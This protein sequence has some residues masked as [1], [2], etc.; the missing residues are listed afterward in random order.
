MATRDE[1]ETAIDDDPD[2]ADNYLVLADLLQELVDPRGEL[3]TL[4]RRSGAEVDA[5]RHAL[6]R[7]LAPALPGTVQWFYGFVRSA[8]C[9]VDEDDLEELARGLAHPS[10][11]FVQSLEVELRGS[12]YDDRQWLLDAIA[13]QP[14]RCLRSLHVYSYR[15]GGNEPPCGD[16]DLSA[17]W[18]Q[19]PRVERVYA[20]ARY[21]TPGAVRSATLTRLELDGEVAVKDLEPLLAGGAPNLRELT[22]HDVDPGA[23]AFALPLDGSTL[24]ARL[25]KLEL[26]RATGAAA[27]LIRAW[28]PAATFKGPVD[29]DRYEQTGE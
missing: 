2:Q 23:F 7:E 12:L 26:P 24:G 6:E 3:I 15:R 21:V 29:P 13:E 19:L 16:F 14:R 18:A 20:G 22:L 4:Y 5:R 27:E 9:R 17:I 11:R 10:M 8:R 1:L 28:C 25:T